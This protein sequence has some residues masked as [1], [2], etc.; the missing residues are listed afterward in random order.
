MASSNKGESHYF[1]VLQLKKYI[2]KITLYTLN[3]YLFFQSDLHKMD[4]N[5][6]KKKKFKTLFHSYKDL[7]IFIGCGQGHHT[8]LSF[9]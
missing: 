2:L 7:R 1:P 8:Q 3:I 6:E 5:K 4:R 9:P